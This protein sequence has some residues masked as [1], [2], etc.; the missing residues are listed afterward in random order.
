VDLLYIAMD[1]TFRIVGWIKKGAQMSAKN[2]MF[3]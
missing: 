3:L 1:A 2:N